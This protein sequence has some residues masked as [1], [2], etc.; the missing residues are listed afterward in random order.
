[1]KLFLF[2]LINHSVLFPK[3]N[4]ALDLWLKV[5]LVLRRK[6]KCSL[7]L[8]EVPKTRLALSSRSGL[9]GFYLKGA[10]VAHFLCAFLPVGTGEILAFQDFFTVP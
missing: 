4:V 7:Q 2:S 8:K 9:F 5:Q 6:G 3:A 1:M 10:Q